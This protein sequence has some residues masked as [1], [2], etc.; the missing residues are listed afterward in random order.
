MWW[1][2]ILSGGGQQQGC[3]PACPRRGRWAWSCISGLTGALAHH[4]LP[5]FSGVAHRA[6]ENDVDALCN[7]REFFNY[8]PLSNQDPAPVL[9]C[10]DPRWVAGWGPSLAPL[11][12]LDL[13]DLP[14]WAAGS[15]LW[16]GVRCRRG[17]GMSG[18]TSQERYH[19]FVKMFFFLNLFLA[20]LCGMRD[21]SSPARDPTCPPSSG[22]VVS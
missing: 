8:L 13:Q 4:I 2:A 11:L 16:S 14:W 18:Y 6:F 9:E 19:L 21:V 3:Q 1:D 5:V 7:L 10:H 22:I 12:W 20:M 17:G 15:R